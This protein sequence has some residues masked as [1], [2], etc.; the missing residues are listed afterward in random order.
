MKR[1]KLARQRIATG[2]AE[3]DFDVL[4]REI[5]SDDPVIQS[6]AIDALRTSDANWPVEALLRLI[7]RDAKIETLRSALQAVAG[8]V[9]EPAVREAVLQ[10]LENDTRVTVLYAASEVAGGLLPEQRAFRAILRAMTIGNFDPYVSPLM[11]DH[12]AEV[13]DALLT[14]LM[15]AAGDEDVR[16][17]RTAAY[18]ISKSF[19][20]ADTLLPLLNDNDEAIRVSALEGLE[21]ISDP[22][23][24]GPIIKACY[25]END[26]IR[27]LGYRW[28]LQVDPSM[29]DERFLSPLLFGLKHGDGWAR[30]RIP[31]RLGQLGDPRAIEPLIEALDWPEDYMRGAVVGALNTLTQVDF[32]DDKVR[33]REWWSQKKGQFIDPAIQRQAPPK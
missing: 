12:S 1:Q 27:H 13:A 4:V 15:E 16:I 6:M 2:H 5:Q 21:V 7:H 10:V 22:R 29:Y 20:R 3:G 24:I 18:V 26:H 23:V 14:Q 25:D 17:R 31:D 32:G 28:L 8:R 19:R 9:T 33:W 11:S 30:N